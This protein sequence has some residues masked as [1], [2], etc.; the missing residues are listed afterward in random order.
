MHPPLA[1]CSPGRRTMLSVNC[2]LAMLHP[3]RET[4]PPVSKASPPE[5]KVVA[6]G[7][8]HV[9]SGKQMFPSGS[10]HVMLK[11]CANEQIVRRPAQVQDDVKPSHANDGSTS[12]ARYI[13]H[14]RPTATTCIIGTAQTGGVINGGVSPKL[15]KTSKLVNA[16]QHWQSLRNI[17][18]TYW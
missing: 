11:R 18:N 10:K 15:R 1:Q 16:A 17:A 3:G 6:S 9:A 13:P 7:K 8:R 5:S 2:H 12:A 14:T 4:V